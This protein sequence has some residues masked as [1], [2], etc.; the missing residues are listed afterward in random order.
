MTGKPK[1][2]LGKVVFRENQTTVEPFPHTEVALRHQKKTAALIAAAYRYQ[3]EQTDRTL[4]NLLH[5]A[6]DL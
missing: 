1:L 2:I 6:L 4:A 5:A 3:E